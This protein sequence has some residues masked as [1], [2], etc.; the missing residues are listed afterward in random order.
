MV[1]IVLAVLGMAAGYVLTVFSYYFIT[2]AVTSLAP[3]AVSSNGRFLSSYLLISYA[4]W[5]LC[6]FAGG[7][8]ATWLSGERGAIVM[9]VL[10][11]LVTW[12][13]PIEAMKQ[14]FGL[15]R[16]VMPICTIL[17]VGTAIYLKFGF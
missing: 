11:V 12:I 5:T 7:L 14:L 2:L 8:T 1:L 6:V 13:H 10:L 4:L 16:V 15:S 17:G 9:G 3:H